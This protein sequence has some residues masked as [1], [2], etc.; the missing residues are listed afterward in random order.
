MAEKKWMQKAAT[1]MEK[2]GT[3]G[4]FTRWC[5]SKGYGG[6]TGECIRAGLKAGGKMAKKAAFAKAARSVSRKK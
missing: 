3:V 6:V 5:K 2:K 1:R 4:S